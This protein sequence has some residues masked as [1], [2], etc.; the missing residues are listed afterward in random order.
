MIKVRKIDVLI[1]YAS[2]FIKYFGAFILL[3]FIAIGVT[4]SEFAIWSIFTAIGGFIN[5]LDI[6]YGVVVSR[7]TLYSISG[8][9]NLRD[10]E[11]NTVR[12]GK[13]NTIN[14]RMLNSV[15]IIS[16]KI[17]WKIALITFFVLV[18][19]TPYVIYIFDK[20]YD[21]LKGILVWSIFSISTIIHMIALSNSTIVKGLGKVRELNY[22]IM[23]SSLVNV[24]SKIILLT[25]NLGLF[26]LTFSLLID[27]ILLSM[28]YR[29]TV[30]KFIVKNKVRKSNKY[31]D[32]DFKFLS[33]LIKNKTK[34]IAVVTISNFIQNQLFTLI[35]PLF[36]SLALLGRYTFTWQLISMIGSISSVIYST[37]RIKMANLKITGEIEKYRKMLSI[38]IGSFL[39]IYTIGILFFFF[40]MDILLKLIDS[41][42]SMLDVM[43]SLMLVIYSLFLTIVN[44][45][46]DIIS[47]ENNQ[48]YVASLSISSISILL[49]TLLFL[50]F[51]FNVYSLATAGILV[52]SIYIIW[53]WPGLV[54]KNNNLSLVSIVKFN[55]DFL[56]DI[57]LGIKRRSK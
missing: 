12:E 47:L 37:Y 33:S 3:P 4:E 25:L 31:G 27:A 2:F 28:A 22:I 17:Y 50:F 45:A 44:K 21:V 57:F 56:K 52:N 7:F 41:N 23:V 49:I 32:D 19:I 46:T 36:I 39:A 5:L 43:P 20:E 38:I 14:E 10:I 16:S 48:E 51:N 34:G 9:E 35:A 42:I 40:T 8:I 1:G 26:A 18:I 53:K 11:L 29:I 6:G 15:T 55:R 30:K 13:P 54:L 24:T